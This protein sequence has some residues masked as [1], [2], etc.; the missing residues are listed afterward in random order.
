VTPKLTLNLGL[1][2]DFA[3]PLYERNNN[4]SDFNPATDTMTPATNGSLFDRSLVHPD[5]KN[6]GPRIGLAYSFM[7]KTVFRAAYGI[8]YDYFNRVGS[9]LEGINAPQALFG[10]ISQSIPPG[11][12]VPAN[13]LITKNSFTTGIDN[14][15]NFNPLVSNVVYLPPN[16]PWPYIQTWFAGIQQEITKST[17]FE[18]DYNGNHSLDLPIIADYN[19]AAPNAPGGTLSIAARVPIPTFGPITWVDPVGNNNYNGLSLRVEHRFTDGLYFLN[20]FT[21]GKA[22]GDSEQAL[23]YYSGYVEANPQNIH[24]LAAEYGP[25]SFDVKLNNVTSIVYQLPF[26]KGQKFGSSMNRGEDAAIGGW[27]INFINTAHTGTPLNVYYGP[28]STESVSSLSNDYRGEPFLRP[29]V[30]GS[31]TSQST[32]Q[33]LNTYFAGYTFTIPPVNAP[34]GDISRN[35]FRAPGFEQLD[36]SADKTWTIHENIRIQFR[37]EFFNVLNHT[38]FGIPTTQTTSS[39][40]GT[41]RTTYPARQIQFGAKLLF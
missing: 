25:S 33:M 31:A 11:G 8:S 20:S 18:I 26:G 24:D 27:E 40:F 34:F 37:S 15:A 10:V 22:L 30:T 29:D 39:A 23:E 9:A 21:W 17:I 13:F 35:D 1:R 32:A 14:P 38:N 4:Y 3:T 6:Y 5:Y 16:S 19:Q 12:P 41:I 28:T 36:F 7:P 2:W